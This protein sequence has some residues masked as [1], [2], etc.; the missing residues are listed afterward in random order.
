MKISINKIFKD[1]GIRVIY[2][3]I[4]KLNRKFKFKLFKLFLILLVNGFIEGLSVALIFS[5]LSIIINPNSIKDNKLVN[6][7]SENLELSDF[8][9]I[10]IYITFL[11][12][13]VFVLSG[14]LKIINLWNN[15][16]ISESI[17]TYYSTKILDNTLHQIICIILI[18]HQ[19]K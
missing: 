8:N 16:S 18:N 14:F 1:S 15:S 3:L 5:F 6:I 4:K 2:Q 12:V 11:I 7:I 17:G 19:M 9:Q 13:F 10:L